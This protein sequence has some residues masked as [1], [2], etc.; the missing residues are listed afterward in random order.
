VALRPPQRQVAVLPPAGL[1][2]K[3]RE[4]A[5]HVDQVP[6]ALGLPDGEGLVGPPARRVGVLAP[7]G[8]DHRGAELVEHVVVR[9]AGVAVVERLEAVHEP[10]LV[11]R[12]QAVLGGVPAA[13][14]APRRCSVQDSRP[15]WQG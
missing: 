14:S 7:F 10:E 12:G 11:E 13:L 5:V 8:G 3:G 2:Q 4:E 6:Q 1:G 9:E 15:H